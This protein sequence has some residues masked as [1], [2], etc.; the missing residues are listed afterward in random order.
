MPAYKML[1]EDRACWKVVGMG[2]E[3]YP[4][5]AL[6]TRKSTSYNHGTAVRVTTAR[7]LAVPATHAPPQRPGGHEENLVP[8]S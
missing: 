3:I 6:L 8:V 7:S 2:R 5:L 4:V 1:V